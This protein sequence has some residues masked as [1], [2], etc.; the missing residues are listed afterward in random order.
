ML[1]ADNSWVLVIFITANNGF[2]V[3]SCFTASSRKER[4]STPLRK[5]CPSFE[6]KQRVS[7][8]H[9]DLGLDLVGLIW[10]FLIVERLLPLVVE[11]LLSPILSSRHVSRKSLEGDEVTLYFVVYVFSRV[12]PNNFRDT[13][14]WKRFIKIDGVRSCLTELQ[15]FLLSKV[16]V[17]PI[18]RILMFLPCCLHVLFKTRCFQVDL[19]RIFVFFVHAIHRKKE[20][21]LSVSQNLS[22]RYQSWVH[23]GM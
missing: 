9:H 17:D 2:P 10:N 13:I 22:S 23:D 19:V 6:G 14:G 12:H 20:Y 15:S 1:R 16:D 18:H 8:F 5:G 11:Q 3:L 7:P 21:C 4:V